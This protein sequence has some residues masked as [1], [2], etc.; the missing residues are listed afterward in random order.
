MLLVN[1]AQTSA[2]V[3]YHT[4]FE[5]DMAGNGDY[6]GWHTCKLNDKIVWSFMYSDITTTG[7]NITGNEK[8]L[9]RVAKDTSVKPYIVGQALTDASVTVTGVRF[10]YVNKNSLD[11]KVYCSDDGL[12]WE[13]IGTTF[14]SANVSTGTLAKIEGLSKKG[15]FFLK[16]EASGS[17]SK[18]YNRDVIVDEVVVTGTMPSSYVK[19]P[20]F[21]AWSRVFSEPFKVTLSQ[22]D[23]KA[24]YFTMDGTDPT[25]ANGTLYD[26]TPITIDKTTTL[27]AAAKDNDQWSGA[28][29]AIYTYQTEEM[30]PAKPVIEGTAEFTD[31]TLVKITAEEGATILYTVDGTAPTEVSPQYQTPLVVKK[32]TT[33]KAV[34]LKNG[35]L[36]EVS[37]ANFVRKDQSTL[38]IMVVGDYDLVHSGVTTTGLGYYED[39]YKFDTEGDALVLEY[40]GKANVLEFDLSRND[41]GSF[42]T[43][44]S[45]EVTASEDGNTWDMIQTF[46]EDTEHATYLAELDTTKAYRYI[47]FCY[48]AK[49]KGS[50]VAL[51][52]IFLVYCPN[53]TLRESKTYTPKEQLTFDEVTLNCVLT[54]GWNTLC[55]PFGMSTAQI[56]QTFG[57][58]AQVAKYVGMNNGAAEFTTSEQTID[59]NEPCL[60]N[61]TTGGDNWYVG[62]TILQTGA[63]R[64]ITSGDDGV[65]LV[66]NYQPVEAANG[67]YVLK[68]NRWVRVQKSDAAVE[69]INSFQAYMQLPANLS[70]DNIY[71]RLSEAPTGVSFVQEDE[72]SEVCYRMDGTVARRDAGTGRLPKGIYVCKRRK[73]IVN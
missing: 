9:M 41:V 24:I 63:A 44:M 17:V 70:P 71:I 72:K 2:T 39:A 11:V 37:T 35:M 58:D 34:A 26:G 65:Q 52:N 42:T 12:N 51:A 56:A 59:A 45:F 7:N 38:P 6:S 28:V 13:Q 5:Y 25:G 68:N 61:V 62:Y 10:L 32:R 15:L 23:Q 29:K 18:D 67:R 1:V 53:D 40:E 43:G 46:G 66:G 8:V 3:L 27:R 20:K 57:V 47:K 54:E 16:I 33:V 49:P 21:D 60:L 73:F 14:K 4:S 64:A 36:S 69:R 48:T 50:N 31:S 55:L 22:D 30:R 19:S